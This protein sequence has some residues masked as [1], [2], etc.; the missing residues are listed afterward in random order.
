MSA[1]FGLNLILGVPFTGTG[2]PASGAL[3]RGPCWIGVLSDG[4][5][6]VEEEGSSL[7]ELDVVVGSSLGVDRSS[8]S[9]SKR[10]SAV[11]GSTISGSAISGSAG[12]ASAVS[13][14]SSSFTA[15]PSCCS[16][17]MTTLS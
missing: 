13:G 1:E 12:S 8:V 7:T 11:S 2:F 5:G 16:S 10:G 9:A 4:L 6:D 14:S 3:E 17:L 15:S